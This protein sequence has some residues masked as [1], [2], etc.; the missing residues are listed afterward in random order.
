[1]TALV[2]RGDE[3]LALGDVVAA[4]R[5]YERAA[6]TG[7]ARAAARAGTTYDP[8]F[9]LEAGLRGITP[10]PNKAADWYRKAIDHGDVAAQERWNRLMATVA[11]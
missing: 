2:R 5:F 3:L 7:S 1:M 11:G 10:N 6:A 9:F 8:A 4:R